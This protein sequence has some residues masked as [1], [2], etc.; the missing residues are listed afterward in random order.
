MRYTYKFSREG[1]GYDVFK[2]IS[3]TEAVL[4]CSGVSRQEAIDLI[5]EMEG[6]NE[7]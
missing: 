2:L 6:E 5:N 1:I 4:L 7:K 3:D